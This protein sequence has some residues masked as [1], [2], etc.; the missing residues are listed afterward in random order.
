MLLVCVWKSGANKNLDPAV[1]ARLDEAKEAAALL[2]GLG[3]CIGCVNPNAGDSLTEEQMEEEMEV[4]DAEAEADDAPPLVLDGA[5]PTLA[6]EAR[7]PCHGRSLAL[8]AKSSTDRKCCCGCGCCFAI[9]S[10]CA[11]IIPCGRRTAGRGVVG[12]TSKGRVSPMLGGGDCC[13]ERNG[14][15]EGDA[16][17]E[18]VAVCISVVATVAVLALAIAV[19][20][21]VSAPND[22]KGRKAAVL[23]SAYT[24]PPRHEGQRWMHELQCF[25]VVCATLRHPCAV[26]L[27]CVPVDSG[28]FA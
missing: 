11:F 22:R 7:P 5:Q 10:R 19:Q 27:L 21:Y 28:A 9:C 13:S 14:T 8:H 2:A 26:L 20:P 6:L 25:V 15:T 4:M 18:F 3:S 24:P 12:A 23:S 16:S 17:S 1:A